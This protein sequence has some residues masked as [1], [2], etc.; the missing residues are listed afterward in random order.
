M[1]PYAII[2]YLT[3]YSVAA[4]G[5]LAWKVAEARRL[6]RSSREAERLLERVREN[7]F[8]SISAG[9]VID[10]GGQLGAARLDHVAVCDVEVS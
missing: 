8:K 5:L 6:R 9:C 7:M 3:G 10:Y 1:D 2:A 4:T